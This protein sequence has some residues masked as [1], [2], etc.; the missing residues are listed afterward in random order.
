VFRQNASD[1]VLVDLEAEC[2]CDN[3]RDPRAG[4]GRTYT[5]AYPAEDGSGNAASDSAT[6][7]VP[8]SQSKK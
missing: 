4:D 5:V 1:N 7:E 2:S 3:Q 6:V 8:K